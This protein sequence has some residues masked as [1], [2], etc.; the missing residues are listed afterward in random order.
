MN[1]Y[2]FNTELLH[3]SNVCVVIEL[4]NENIISI[5]DLANDIENFKIIEYTHTRHDYYLE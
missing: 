2:Y 5:F 1:K 4:N 3:K